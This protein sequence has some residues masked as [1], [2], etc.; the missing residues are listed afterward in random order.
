M[1]NILLFDSGPTDSQLSIGYPQMRQLR[2]TS[3][4]I[5]RIWIHGVLRFMVDTVPHHHVLPTRGRRPS[6]REQQPSVEGDLQV[7]QHFPAQRTIGQVAGSR[8]ADREKG[9]PRM[10]MLRTLHP[11]RDA[12]RT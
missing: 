10:R 2:E 1:Y 12:V 11:T 9:T 5:S 7:S 4:Q 6:D 3:L 8:K